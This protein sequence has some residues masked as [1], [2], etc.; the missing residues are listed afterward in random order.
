M[1][2]EVLDD[3]SHPDA[4]S[5]GADIERGRDELA[6]L[7][8]RLLAGVWLREQSASDRA[9]ACDSDANRSATASARTG[10]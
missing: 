4:A 7:V 9:N 2:R 8:G 1:A 5:T 10:T 3:A 6:E